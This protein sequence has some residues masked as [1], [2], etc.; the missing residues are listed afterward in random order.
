MSR[1]L[2]SFSL[3]TIA[4]LVIGGLL[5]GLL[6]DRVLADPRSAEDQLWTFG[7]V[8]AL[9]EDQYIGETD[10]RKLVEDAIDGMLAELDPHSNYL[11]PD[12]FSEMRDEQRGKFSGL[13]IQITKRGKDNPLTIIAPIDDTPA[14][15]AGLQSGDVISKIEGEPTVEMTVQ[16]AVRLLKGDKGTEVTITIQRPSLPEPFDV[17]IQ[18]DDIPIESIR[19]AFML[20]PGV[21]MIRISNFTSTSADELD[22]A[23]NELTA[24]GMNRL[25]LDLRSNPGGLLDQ[26][27]QVAER[28]IPAGRLIVYTRGR[29]AGSNQDYVAKRNIE[30]INL[31]LVVLVDRY[32]ASASEIVAGAIQDHD[33]GLL[34][35]ETTFGKGLVQ[36]VIELGDRG[37]LAVT[38]AKYYTPSGRL[39]QRD[40]SDFEE[41][42]LSRADDEASGEVPVPPDEV[43]PEPVEDESLIFYTSSGRTVYGGGGIRPDYT[44]KQEDASQLLLQLIRENVIFE[45]AVRYSNGHPDL[46][47][48]FQADESLIEEFAAYLREREFDFDPEALEEDEE[49]ISLR[50]RSQVARVKWDQVEESRV[51]AEADPQIQRA[52]ELFGEAA[53]LSRRGENGRP[54]KEKSADLRA[55]AAA[56]IRDSR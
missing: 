29:I 44:V 34:V 42:Y 53:E 28:F 5:G 47:K 1:Q 45:F 6:S 4:F 10:S 49:V 17:T 26:A 51:L 21:G 13:G 55:R 43:A 36:R 52:L 2:R 46:E 8:L 19:V 18:R 35:G 31:P 30:R 50:I 11:D 15:R 37:A 22:R 39:I 25:L 9:V 41:Y 33:R 24:Q 12:S 23:I 40:Y 48:G 27:V 54:G 56:E 14:A 16:Q 32:S 38:T 3:L 20:E 7:R